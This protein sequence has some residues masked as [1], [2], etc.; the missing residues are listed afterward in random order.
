MVEDTTI[1]KI[2]R[3]DILT[4][5]Y[6]AQFMMVKKLQSMVLSIDNYPRRVKLQRRVDNYPRRVKLQRRVAGS[7]QLTTTDD[8]A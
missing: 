8:T 2:S 5:Y 4:E 6:N 7:M 1:L 3:G